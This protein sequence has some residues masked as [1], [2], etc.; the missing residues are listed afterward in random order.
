MITLN[1]TLGVYPAYNGTVAKLSQ[2]SNDFTLIFT[3]T[4]DYGDFVLE[5][6]T[7]AQI[8]GTKADG[9]GYSANCTIDIEAQTVTVT[10][11]EQITAAAGDNTFEI[12]LIKDGKILNTVNFTIWVERAALDAGTITSDS[13]LLELNAIIEG[14]QT[15]TQAAA[16]ASASAEEA[17]TSAATLRLDP[18]LTQ[19][20][21]SADAKVV[22]DALA[23]GLAARYSSASPYAVGD[24]MLK[25]NVLYH[26]TRAIPAGG[27][28][29][30]GTNVEIAPL[31]NAV[32][33]LNSNSFT[34]TSDY[35]I[36]NQ[37]CGKT[38]R[39]VTINAKIAVTAQTEGTTINLATIPTGY[40]PSTEVSVFLSDD[41]VPSWA[42]GWITTAGIIRLTI[43]ATYTGSR[44]FRVMT[45]YY[46]AS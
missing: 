21:E 23:S 12:R 22:G 14:A 43:P 1:Y 20:G 4:N 34:L 41:Y 28:V 26:V 31:G 10:G 11:D 40:R 25:D 16:S 37:A 45:S 36:D 7:T 3:L 24:Y 13:V 19:S 18:T 33:A 42:K 44:K 38:G 17:A 32:T 9:N 30:V 6:G 27:D 5:D 15:A 46:A 8:R 39:L 2:Y 35:T 29:T